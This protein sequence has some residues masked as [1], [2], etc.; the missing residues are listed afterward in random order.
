MRPRALELDELLLTLRGETRDGPL[1]L[2]R[3]V[4]DLPSLLRLLDLFGVLGLPHP[5]GLPS[6][7]GLLLAQTLVLL[8]GRLLFLLAPLYGLSMLLRGLGVLPLLIRLPLLVGLGARLLALRLRLLLFLMLVLGGLLPA[9]LFLLLCLRVVLLLL[10]L[11]LLLAL[12]FVFLL[13]LL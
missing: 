12:L 7:C 10:L 1:R 11:V 6:L 3:L 2:V 4:L 13:A 9:F 8:T 5:L